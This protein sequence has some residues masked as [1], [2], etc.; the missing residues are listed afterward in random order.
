M[1]FQKYFKKSVE[2]IKFVICF[3]FSKKS[4]YMFFGV[5]YFYKE[6]VLCCGYSYSFLFWFVVNQGGKCLGRIFY[7][8][9]RRVLSFFFQRSQ[10]VLVFLYGIKV[11]LVAKRS[12][13]FYVMFFINEEVLCV[14]QEL[15]SYVDLFQKLRIFFVVCQV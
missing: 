15:N 11:I 5:D 14:F 4:I 6:K 8:K 12:F 10:K 1:C 13:C 9:K 2:L 3:F 7:R